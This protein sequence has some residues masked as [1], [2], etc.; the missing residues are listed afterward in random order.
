MES[1]IE[2][3]KHKKLIEWVAGWEKVC[4]PTSV[5]WC[6]GNHP[7]G[8]D[9]KCMCQVDYPYKAV[10]ALRAALEKADAALRD[11]G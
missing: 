3:T 7:S 6:D 9:A 4:Q 11:A 8:W 2:V 10:A 5:Y 1:T